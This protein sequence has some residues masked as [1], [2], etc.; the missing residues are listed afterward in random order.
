MAAGSF[1]CVARWTLNRSSVIRK[2]L[3]WYPGERLSAEPEKNSALLSL[4]GT[5]NK[6]P[7]KFSAELSARQDF[8]SGGKDYSGTINL[9]MNF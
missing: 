4:S 8:N 5:W 9:G 6:G 7:F 2:R 1:Y 3:L